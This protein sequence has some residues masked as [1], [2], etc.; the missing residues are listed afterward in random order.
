MVVSVVVFRLFTK[1]SEFPAPA[2]APAPETEVVKLLVPI[3]PERFPKAVE[4]SGNASGPDI[5]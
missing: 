3:L 5:P 1:I 2:P 4:Y